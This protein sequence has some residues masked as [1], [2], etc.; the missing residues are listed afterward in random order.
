MATAHGARAAVAVEFRRYL[1]GIL[2]RAM[3]M[4]LPAGLQEDYARALCISA[5][6]LYVGEV[7]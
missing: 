4:R 5:R 3:P 6:L 1:S 7:S 2:E